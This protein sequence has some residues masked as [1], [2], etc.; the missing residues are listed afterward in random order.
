MFGS[1]AAVLEEVKL[2]LGPDFSALQEDEGW[3]A[4][5]W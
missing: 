1:G 2:T 4:S 5:S 3:E